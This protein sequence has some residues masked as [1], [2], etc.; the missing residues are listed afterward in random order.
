MD[1]NNTLTNQHLPGCPVCQTALMFRLAKG[2]KSSKP[3]IMLMCPLDGRHFRGFIGD[4]DY[5]KQVMEKLE[6]KTNL[7]EKV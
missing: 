1:N 5:I 2:R 6:E 7:D 4:R 3:F